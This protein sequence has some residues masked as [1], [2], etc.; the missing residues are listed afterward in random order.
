MP[1]YIDS[2][3]FV[4]N[5]NS[6]LVYDF[7]DKYFPLRRELADDYV[8]PKYSD[9]PEKIF[10]SAI[11]LLAYLDENLNYDYIAYW[12]NLDESNDIK[13]FTLQY[14]DDGKMIFGVSIYGREP[15]SEKSVQVFNEVRNYLNSPIACITGEEPPPW[16]SIDFI[17]FCNERYHPARL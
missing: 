17:D 8:I 14:T 2:Y 3:Y 13:Q 7:L 10:Y 11:D 9:N 15:E 5:R 4:D 6:K 12:E 1:Q 16:N